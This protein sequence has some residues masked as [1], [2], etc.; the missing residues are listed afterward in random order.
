VTNEFES[1]TK[2]LR[3]ILVTRPSRLRVRAASRRPG[4]SAAQRRVAGVPGSAPD[5]PQR[6]PF[7]T[8]WPSSPTSLPP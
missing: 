8:R 4:E 2:L 6:W 5:I 1:H 3:P 7:Q